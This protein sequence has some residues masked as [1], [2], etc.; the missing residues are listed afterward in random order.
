MKE[1]QTCLSP[2]F[3][4]DIVLFYTEK[5]KESTDMLAALAY[6]GAAVI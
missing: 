2:Y 6:W 1:R 4:T 3:T 5:Q